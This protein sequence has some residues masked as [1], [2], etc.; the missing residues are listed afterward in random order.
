MYRLTKESFFEYDEGAC[1]DLGG[2]GGGEG[3]GHNE[4]MEDH[5]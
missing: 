2:G 4:I 1:A 5:A 3:S